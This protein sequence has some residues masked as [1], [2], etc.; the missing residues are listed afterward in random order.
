MTEMTVSELTEMEVTRITGRK[1]RKPPTG[2]KNPKKDKQRFKIFRQV[3]FMSEIQLQSLLDRTEPIDGEEEGMD[4]TEV[5]GERIS[6]YDIKALKVGSK[7]SKSMREELNKFNSNYIGAES[8]FPVKNGA[9]RILTQFKDNPYTLELQD[10]YTTGN[11]PKPL[12]TIKG[13]HYQGKPATCKVLEHFVRTTPVVERCDDPRCFSRLVIVPKRDPGTTKDTPPTSYRVTMDALINNCLKPVAST[14]PLATDEIKKLHGLKYFLKLDAMHAF[15]AIPLDEESKK[16]MAFQTHEG[17]F[18]WSRLTMGC[19]PASQV[20]QTAFHTAMDNH[21]PKEYRHRI[22][23]YADDM[24]AGANTLEE[25][26]EIYKALVITLHKAGIQVKASKVEFGV[27]EVTFHNYRVVGGDGPMAN[28]TTPKD[29][30]LDPI[31]SCT[32]PSRS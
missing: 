4:M 32:I 1:L 10:Q 15:W 13:T 28:T 29:E 3:C 9:P 25:L 6:K 20:Q 30:N 31:K 19:R 11:K 14:L 2:R 27:E 12:P 21:M 16:L 26:F 7:V 23:L 24:A 22:A 17:V 18:A 5:N 8:V